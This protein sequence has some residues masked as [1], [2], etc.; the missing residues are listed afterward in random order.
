MAHDQL[1]DLL[2]KAKAALDMFATDNMTSADQLF[3][4]LRQA[5]AALDTLT[6]DN[7]ILSDLSDDELDIVVPIVNNFFNSA[8]AAANRLAVL[9]N[10]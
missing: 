3:E 9:R 10:A 7:S 2:K 6:T 8:Q 4:L 1:F 5:K